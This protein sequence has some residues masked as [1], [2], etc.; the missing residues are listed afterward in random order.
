VALRA[1]NRRALTVLAA[2]V[3]SLAIVVTA[4]N[5]CDPWGTSDP[6]RRI[7]LT[8]VT[9]AAVGLTLLFEVLAVR[10]RHSFVRCPHCRGKLTPTVALVVASGCCPHCGGRV[11]DPPADDPPADVLIPRADYL[12]ADNTYQGRGV[13]VLIGG[14]MTC[15]I[16]FAAAMITLNWSGLPFPLNVMAF[17]LV[18]L[19]APVSL[20]AVLRVLWVGGKRNPA[21]ACPSCGALLAGARMMVIA[22]GRCHNCGRKAIVPRTRPLPPPHLGKLWTTPRLIAAGRHLRRAAW[23]VVALVGL[24]GATT[25]GLVLMGNHLWYEDRLR[26]MGLNRPMAM[27]VEQFGSPAVGITGVVVSLVVSFHTLRWGRRKHPADCPRCGREIMPSFVLATRCC[28]RCGW[29][30]V[31]EPGK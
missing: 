18:L 22:T 16:G 29:R 28:N 19:V 24:I 31:A 6:L 21:L 11:L 12:A 1:L 5:L 23:W 3:A 10:A 25:L 17:I 9:L 27:W 30:I 2:I 14:L 8:W 4:T 13:P 20:A 26:L 15:Y 7:G